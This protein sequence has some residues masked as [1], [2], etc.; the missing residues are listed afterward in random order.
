MAAKVDYSKRLGLAIDD[1]YNLF[2]GND[3]VQRQKAILEGHL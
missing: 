2:D 3:S 1:Y